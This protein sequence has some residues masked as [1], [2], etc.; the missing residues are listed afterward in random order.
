MSGEF[1]VY[2]LIASNCTGQM[3][4]IDN[5][6][7]TKPVTSPSKL[8]LCIQSVC[9]SQVEGTPAGREEGVGGN[10]RGNW[11]KFEDARGM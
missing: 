11:L 4:L 7:I 9:H 5:Q 3:S 2:E 10:T 1:C 8:S 6:V